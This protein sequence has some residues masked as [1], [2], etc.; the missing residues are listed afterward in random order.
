MSLIVIYGSTRRNGNT[1]NLTKVVL[2]QLDGI[3][4]TEEFLLEYSIEPIIDQR[5]DV[6][7]F[8]D[9]NDDYEDLIK[10]V[11]DHDAI[12]FV[13][14]LYWYGMSGRMKNFIDRWSQSIRNK[15]YD[16]K[17]QMNGKKVYLLIVGGT[18]APVTALP[19]V[20]QFQLI[21][22]FLN[23][24]LLGYTIG[25]G[26][27]PLEVLNDEGSIVGAKQLG[28]QIKNNLSRSYYNKSD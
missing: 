7:G 27:K 11:L 22:Q 19:L 26:V 8:D 23:M 9:V 13:T 2:E 16:F 6:N 14:P 25:R 24:E 28:V 21:S 3:S 4:I 17:K 18:C 15:S 10:K 5:H 20:Q 12:L 1:E